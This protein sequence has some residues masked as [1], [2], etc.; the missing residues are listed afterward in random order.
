MHH[1]ITR[2]LCRVYY[3]RH[4]CMLTGTQLSLLR[5]TLAQVH[6][7]NRSCRASV[8]CAKMMEAAATAAATAA[9]ATDHH[10][11]MHIQ[12]VQHVT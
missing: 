12:P 5:A 11:T 1:D 6:V 4:A 9:T 3:V 8:A 7:T 2:A 10:M